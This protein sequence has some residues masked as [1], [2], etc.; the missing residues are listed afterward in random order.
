MIGAL[1]DAVG[2]QG[3][4]LLPAYYLPG[5]TVRATCDMQDYVFD[6]RRACCAA[7]RACG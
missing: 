1:Q 5:G 7:R 3:T 2:P 4:L 6:A